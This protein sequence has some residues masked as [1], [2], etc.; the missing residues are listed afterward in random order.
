MKV[1]TIRST[2]NPE[3]L[4][5]QTARGDYF[6]GYVADASVDELMDGVEHDEA[7]MQM[8]VKA[9]L[10]KQN[11]VHGLDSD[12]QSVFDDRDITEDD[13]VDWL[14][15]TD[16]ISDVVATQEAKKASLVRRLFRREH[17]GPFEHPQITIAFKGVSRSLMAQLTRHRHVSFDIQS[18][19]YVDFSYK[20][21]PVATPPSLVADQHM[22]RDDGVVAVDGY[23]SLFND[24]VGDAVEA[25]EQMVDDDVPAED[26]RY[27]LPIGTKVNGTMS[28]NLRTM[29]HVANMREKANAQH[30]IREFTTEVIDTCLKEWAPMVYWLWREHGPLP[31]SP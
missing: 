10:Y 29:L 24:T 19:R 13:L 15:Q 21:D 5:C 27:V 9:L 23:E 18:Q 26:A 12:L 8:G 7:D 14:E 3:T 30:E 11:V 17:W 28:M 4:V 20:D 6:D 1:D 22:T 31:E 25:Y 2:D 16:K